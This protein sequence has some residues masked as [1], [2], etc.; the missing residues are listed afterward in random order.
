V[1][2]AEAALLTVATSRTI[3]MHVGTV[4]NLAAW[5][6][7][8]ANDGQILIDTKVQSAI[9]AAADTGP[10]GELTLKGFHRPVRAFNVRALRP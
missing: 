2:R 3:D 7:A 10:A 1:S 8:D 6:C 9:E 4:V 5:L